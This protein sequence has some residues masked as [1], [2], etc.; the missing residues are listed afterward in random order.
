[1]EKSIKDRIDLRKW[2]ESDFDNAVKLN[3]EAEKDLGIPPESGSWE[4]DMVG[5]S[6]TFLKGGGEFLVGYIGNEM[7]IMGGFKLL[8]K[9]LAEVKRMR[10]LPKYHRKGLASWLLRILEEE[11][12]KRGIV[13]ALV[14]T[15]NVQ[16]AALGLYRSSG[17]REVS[18]VKG[19]HHE[20]EFEVVSFNKE[21]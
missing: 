2:R 17:Y 4:S 16:D 11:M 7:V 9:G 20:S 18:R 3:M 5:I 6:D 15:L 12:R 14:S 19:S 21:L 1:M 8:G 10:V 13:T